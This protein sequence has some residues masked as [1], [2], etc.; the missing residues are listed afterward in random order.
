MKTK[1]MLL[2]L[3]AVATI[4]V[5]MPR[6]HAIVFPPLVVTDP[7][8]TV[9]IQQGLPCGDDLDITRRI[10]GGRI[11]VTPSFIPGGDRAPQVWFNLTKLEL[12]LE[13]F[14]VQRKCMGIEA[15]AEFYEI[16]LRLAA[17]LVFQGEEVGPPGSAKYRFFIPKDDFLLDESIF[18]NAPVPQPERVYQKPSGT[19][20]G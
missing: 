3:G 11:S 6:V 7:T 19:S 8:G 13:P 20:S 18:D 12:F 1:R 16:A 14:S 10:I 5:S 2:M 15:N 9:R 17:G 4:A